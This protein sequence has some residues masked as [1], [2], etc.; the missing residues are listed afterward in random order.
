MAARQENQDSDCWR[1]SRS[2][3]QEGA[4]HCSKAAHRAAAFL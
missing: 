3:N 1:D 2:V 4:H